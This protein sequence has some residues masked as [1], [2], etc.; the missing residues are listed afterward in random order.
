MQKLIVRLILIIAIL[1][2]P[3]K[4]SSYENPYQQMW[5]N[6]TWYNDTTYDFNNKMSK[7]ESM[8]FAN[9]KEYNNYHKVN[10][11]YCI[12]GELYRET[13]IKQKLIKQTLQTH[14]MVSVTCNKDNSYYYNSLQEYNLIQDTIREQDKKFTSG[15]SN[16]GNKQYKKKF[17]KRFKKGN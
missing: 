9:Y 17:T 4:A 12:G 1:L 5:F 11:Y 15:L 7:S 14:N 3:T 13:G 10:R 16:L 2:V 6:K 8:N